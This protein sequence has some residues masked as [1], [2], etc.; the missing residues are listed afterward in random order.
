MAKWS[1]E[2]EMSSIR[3]L[4]SYYRVNNL[5]VVGKGECNSEIYPALELDRQLGTPL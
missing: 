4:S 5:E 2:L 1:I 3:L